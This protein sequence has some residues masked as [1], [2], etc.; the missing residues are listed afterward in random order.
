MRFLLEINSKKSPQLQ[1]EGENLF[2]YFDYIFDIFL[3]IREL[4]LTDQNKNLS[5]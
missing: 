1:E 4:F 2:Y 3:K 5:Y